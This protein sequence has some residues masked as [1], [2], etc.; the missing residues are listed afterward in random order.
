V[1]ILLKYI[2]KLIY[3]FVANTGAQSYIQAMLFVL[4]AF[5]FVVS[6]ALVPVAARLLTCKGI[7][8]LPID[9]SSH[10][11]PTPRG[12]GLVIMPVI[13]LSW[14]GLLLSGVFTWPDVKTFSAVILCGILLCAFTWLDDHKPNGL[15]VRTRLFVQLLAVSI[16]LMLWPLDAGR[17]LPEFIPVVLERILMAL[18]WVWF[19]NLYNF[20]DGINGISGAEAISIT[21]GLLLF[22]FFGP[23]HVPEGFTAITIVPLAAAAGFLV[24][25]ARPVA[26]IFL[27]DVGSVGF[28]YTLA[29]LLFVFAAAGYMIPAVL[30]ALVYCVDATF[31]LLKR[32]WQKKKIWESH[33]EHFYHRV[34]VK[35][36]GLTHL[37][38]VG[39]IVLV[40][41]FL[42][43]LGFML[44]TGIF[45]PMTGFI[46][47]MII[48]CGL[49]VFFFV[50]GKKVG[51]KSSPRPKAFW[52][53]R[54]SRVQI[55][56]FLAGKR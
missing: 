48:V 50:Y 16:P 25:N 19:S 29:W 55:K 56:K 34:T 3:R 43:I 9:R 33:R 7:V 40:N 14:I 41:L 26:K 35:P 27:G 1:F 13:F 10:E 47:G 37:Q 2:N 31:T 23:V 49:L 32:A 38:C 39:L 24:W 53:E 54:F 22:C 4:A 18:A 46:L 42:T 44:L 52:I 17:L 15:R 8:D 5:V 30:L 20:M 28:G 6:T 21:G 51:H 12:G 45:H 36:D 11:I